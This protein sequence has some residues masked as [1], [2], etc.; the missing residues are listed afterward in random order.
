MALTVVTIVALP[1]GAL[2][3]RP[4]G[5]PLHVPFVAVTVALT[6]N[7]VAW[8]AWPVQVTVNVS[9]GT[10]QEP[11]RSNAAPCADQIPNSPATRVGGIVGGALPP[12]AFA[13]AAS[14]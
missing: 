5:R 1:A 11:S 2:T 7:P 13:H 8:V 6:R 10:V 4:A 14:R 9:P 3:A 12:S